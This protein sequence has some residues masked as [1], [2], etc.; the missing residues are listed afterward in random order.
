MRAVKSRKINRGPIATTLG[1]RRSMKN[2]HGG[3]SYWKKAGINLKGT[4]LMVW[5]G[6]NCGKEKR[7]LRKGLSNEIEE[8]LPAKF[9]GANEVGGGESGVRLAECR[10]SFWRL[11]PIRKRKN[12]RKSVW[13]VS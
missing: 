5:G 2:I 8:I 13:E 10:G 3:E 7:V 11:S 9:Y 12:Q 6:T 1:V 4:L